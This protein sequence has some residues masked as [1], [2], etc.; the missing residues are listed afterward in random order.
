MYLMRTAQVP[1]AALATA[2]Y[3]EQCAMLMPGYRRGGLCLGTG[4]KRQL[5]AAD[6][7]WRFI[8]VHDT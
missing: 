1:E 7:Y 8:L 2:V 6:Q 5:V 3:L 4:I